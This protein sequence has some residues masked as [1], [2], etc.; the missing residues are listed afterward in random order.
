MT[1]ARRRRVW[2][3]AV[4]LVGVPIGL[5]A[6]SSVQDGQALAQQACVHVN[7]SV[8][9]W[10]SSQRAGMPA[11]TVATLQ[12][13]AEQ[14]LRLALPL[15]AAANSDDG[16][17]NSLMTTI[18]EIETVDEGHLVPALH[19]QCVL[20]NSNQNVNPQNPNGNS[21]TPG[22]GNSPPTANVN[23]KPASG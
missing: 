14:Q 6:C 1:P 3:G 21:G 16:T 5:A 17:W 7:R 23:P 2:A 12:Q 4:L 8:S 22:G 19:A 11:A 10:V 15:A 9:D 20:A 13:R 18:S